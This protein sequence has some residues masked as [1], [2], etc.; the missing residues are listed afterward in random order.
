MAKKSDTIPSRG[1]VRALTPK[2]NDRIWLVVADSCHARILEGDRDHS[3]VALVLEAAAPRMSGAS[4]T[5]A[6]AMHRGGDAPERHVIAPLKRSL[7]THE[8]QVFFSRLADY[9]GGNAARYDSLVLIAPSRVQ[10]QMKRSL[11]KT[12]LDKVIDRHSE[13]L[14]WM[15]AGEILDHLGTLGKEMRRLRRPANPLPF[16]KRRKSA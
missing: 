6:H 10:Q 5:R 4:R 16:L 13:D 11:P 3:G 2:K 12:L 8:M 15:S 9:L 1:N 7:K 14:T